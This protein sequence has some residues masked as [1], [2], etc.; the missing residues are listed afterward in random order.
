M[1]IGVI[2]SSYPIS[3]VDT[4][5]AGV[6]VRD[7]ALELVALGHEVH[8]I[9][10]RKH[11]TYTPDDELHVRFIQWWGGEKDL[12]SASMYNLPTIARYATLVGS[13]LWSVP[14]YARTHSLDAVLAMWAVPSGLWAWMAWVRWRV[15]YGVWALGSDIWAR[16][17]YPFGDAIVRRVLRDA[18]FRFADGVQ[19]ARDAAELAGRDCEFVPSVRRLS[20][21]RE[22]QIALGPDAPHFLYIGRYERNKGP[23][24]LIEAM[25]LLLDSGSEA[26]LHIFGVGSME[27]LLRERIR[28]YER[29]I[30]LGGYADPETTVA[31]MQACD[32]L[33]IPSRIESIPLI[34]GDALQ[35]RLPVVA[36][37]VGDVGEVVNQYGV[38]KVVPPEDPVAMADAIQWATQHTRTEFEEPLKRAANAFDLAQS[39]ARCAEALSKAA[40][41]GQ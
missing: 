30:T 22:H 8:V 9:T 15:P 11:G 3:P 16:H 19:L 32:W 37:D 21:R 29:H 4:V 18:A 14:H 31:Y 27:P 6:F 34:L 25:R 23:D 2:T 12:A 20:A 17:K 24:V 33:V 38:G 5:T 36:T 7:V 28:G 1:R 40:G 13:G 10:P 35:M 39:A 41:R 26:Y